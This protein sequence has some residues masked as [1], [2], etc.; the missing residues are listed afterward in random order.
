MNHG[1]GNRISVHR[2]KYAVHIFWDLALL[3][4]SVDLH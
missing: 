4:F 3:S 2:L 1:G